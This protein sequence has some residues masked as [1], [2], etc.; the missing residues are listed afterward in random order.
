MLPG[1]QN[2]VE[3]R[4]P[5]AIV[6]LLVDPQSSMLQLPLIK[7]VKADREEYL[8]GVDAKLWAAAHFPGSRF[9]RVPVRRRQ[10]RGIQAMQRSVF[11]LTFGGA[12]SRPGEV[13]APEV[14]ERSNAHALGRDG[15]VPSAQLAVWRAQRRRGRERLSVLGHEVLVHESQR[16]WR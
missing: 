2:L 16:L 3:L 9:E 5:G 10:R 12:R 4:C 6:D 11:T 15:V 8:R 1:Y 13:R 14:D 7:G